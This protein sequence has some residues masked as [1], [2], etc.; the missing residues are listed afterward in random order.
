MVCVLVCFMIEKR[1]TWP[2]GGYDVVGSASWEWNRCLQLC[3]LVAPC[4]EL[5]RT[6]AEKACYH[7]HCQPNAHMED[8][9]CLFD[10][11]HYEPNG[12]EY[13][14]HLIAAV[15]QWSRENSMSTG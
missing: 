2:S 11:A 6:M 12:S 8:G 14:R 4:T 3:T 10:H 1:T 5:V 13:I 15:N 9:K 7:C